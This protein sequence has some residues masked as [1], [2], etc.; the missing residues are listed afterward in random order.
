MT[1]DVQGTKTVLL[2]GWLAA[3]PSASAWRGPLWDIVRARP[4]SSPV[5]IGMAL[6]H[7]VSTSVCNI[8]KVWCIVKWLPTTVCQQKRRHVAVHCRCLTACIT[9]T[10]YLQQK[11]IIRREVSRTFRCSKPRGAR[12]PAVGGDAKRERDAKRET[13]R[14]HA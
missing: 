2:T 1:E 12:T 14:R 3:R 9:A 5:P 10:N 8:N 4:R 11:A 7:W 13:R 6:Y